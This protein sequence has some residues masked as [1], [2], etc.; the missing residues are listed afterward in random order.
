MRRLPIFF[1]IDV[2]ESM[3][4]EPLE[5]VQDGMTSIIRDLK[6]DPY[7]LETAYLSV[8]AFAGKAKTL[9]PLTDVVGF[10]PPQLGVG[11]GTSLGAAL[12]HLM[13]EIDLQIAPTTPERKGDWK[14]LIFLFTDGVPTDD[15]KATMKTWTEKYKSRTNLI[16]VS[17]GEEASMPV[18]KELTDSVLLFN[19]AKDEDY[20]KFFKWVTASIKVSS[21]AVDG[22]SY[23]NG[24]QPGMAPTDD[25]I[26]TKVEITKT[27]DNLFDPRVAVFTAKCQSTKRLYLMKYNRVDMPANIPGMEK[28]PRSMYRLAGGYPVDDNM[29]RDL[30]EAHK[31]DQ[32]INTADLVGYC[33][34]PCCGNQFGFTMCECGNLFCGVVDKVNTCPWCSRQATYSL[35][36][37]GADDDF[38]VNRSIG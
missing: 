21:V 8:I 4:G 2:S 28:M 5:Q 37:G 13:R 33:S 3:I 14:P 19:N 30:T 7:A 15:Y 24:Q 26:F 38:D 32:K 29:Y 20:K 35:S 22:G 11:G 36:S 34:C 25:S 18:L 9:L 12:K 6:T 16:C 31:S 23:G 10:Y 17:F 1:V 27:G